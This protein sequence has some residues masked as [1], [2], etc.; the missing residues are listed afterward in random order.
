MAVVVVEAM[1]D[2]EGG[3][4]VL[5]VMMKQS[6]NFLAEYVFKMI[7]ASAGG[8][9]ETAKRSVEKIT[10]RMS[11]SGVNFNRCVINDGQYHDVD[12]SENAFKTAALMAFREGYAA[13]K[14]TILEPMMKV[15]VQ[16]PEDFQGSVVGQ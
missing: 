11:L 13:A 10:Q 3:T 15:E 9:N 16:A 1:V 8:R 6:N 2:E 5:G 14:P 4:E 7:G 12:S